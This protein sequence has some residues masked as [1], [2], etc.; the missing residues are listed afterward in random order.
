MPTST[1]SAA[2]AEHRQAVEALRQSYRA[3]PQGSPVRLVKRTSNLFRPRRAPD[4]ATGLDVRHFDKVLSIDPVARTAEVQGMTT[5][6]DLADATL[7]HGLLPPVVLDF[8]KITLGGGV[9][10]TGAESSS[11]RAGLPHDQVREMEI[12]TGDG[13]VVVAT[14]DNEHADLFH[15]FPHSYG[16][17]GYALRLQI[18]LEP[19]KPFVRLRHVRMDS[20]ESWISA[21]RRI[22]EDRAWD[23]EP[24]DFVDGVYF[25]PD[26]VH[27][28]LADFT[29]R[30]PY[31]SDYTGSKVYY[32]SLRQRGAD[33]LSTR[34]YLWR[35]D[36]DMYW[37]SRLFGL[38]NP[39]LRRLWPRRARNADLL[40][41]IQMFDRR[42]G[43]TS[44]VRRAVGRPFEWVLQDADLPA[45]SVG[46]FMAFF[47]AEIGI[48]PVW[49]CPMRLREPISLYP[50][51][52]GKLYVS[53]GF[54][55]L[56]PTSPDR[57]ADYLNRL[58]ERK[59]AELGGHKP[60]YSTAHY[61]EDEFWRQYGGDGAYWRLKDAYDAGRRLPDLYDK[62]V[63]AR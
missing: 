9:V 45:E 6:E 46:E 37:T 5:F 31:L 50:M 36:T 21:L 60:L 59:I 26:A 63:L 2:M 10:G 49:L 15:G 22:T 58:I 1:N 35:W 33:F 53:L 12:L 30:A 48:K 54:W 13:R 32:W 61:G 4:R 23:G 16:S 39:V 47:D 41:R 52:P 43:F 3:L 40:R 17:L 44:R 27:L 20:V 25:G 14:R 11:F 18:D 56:V 24:V 55:W 7:A 42:F 62:C 28:V 38:E 8:K 19:A 34:D 29:D 51:E 57:P